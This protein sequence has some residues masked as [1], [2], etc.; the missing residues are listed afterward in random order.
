MKMIAACSRNG[1]T[2]G[3]NGFIPWIRLPAWISFILKSVS[4]E[5]APVVKGTEEEIRIYGTL[6]DATPHPI[7]EESDYFL[8]GSDELALE[9]AILSADE[10][11]LAVMDMNLKE[12]SSFPKIDTEVFSRVSYFCER[13]SFSQKNQQEPWEKDS[14]ILPVTFEHWMRRKKPRKPASQA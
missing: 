8:I 13:V 7:A 14:N 2:T 3:F 4:P 12:G 6:L 5:I 1:L 10:I 11:F 9:N